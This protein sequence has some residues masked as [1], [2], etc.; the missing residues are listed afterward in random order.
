MPEND[1]NYRFQPEIISNKE[2]RERRKSLSERTLLMNKM[3]MLNII[4][5]SLRYNKLLSD[6]D[7]S[8]YGAFFEPRKFA[9]MP[10]ILE[11]RR[12]FGPIRRYSG[13]LN[14]K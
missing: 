7:K 13:N 11:K 14:N 6:N 5:T 3:N 2:E 9:P 8:R 4:Y 1:D 10:L 12:L